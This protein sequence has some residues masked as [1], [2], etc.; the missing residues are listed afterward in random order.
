MVGMV[1]HYSVNLYYKY[2]VIIFGNATLSQDF[3]FVPKKSLPSITTWE[4]GIE[5]QW[6]FLKEN[7][8]FVIKFHSHGHWHENFLYIYTIFHTITTIYDY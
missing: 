3:H 2:N 6:K 8:C 5:W 4:S 7:S 1:M